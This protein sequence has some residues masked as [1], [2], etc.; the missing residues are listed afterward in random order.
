MTID[1]SKHYFGYYANT[2]ETENLAGF[3]VGEIVIDW[4]GE[5][6]CIL[7]IYNSGEVRT[8]S[9]GMGDIAKLKK[10]RNRNRIEEYLK[11][12]HDSDMKHLLMTHEGE[13]RKL[14]A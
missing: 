14:T 1:I 5:T 11:D 3:S 2:G 7:Q 4:Y 8:D 12:L 6:C 9:N 10:T 13:L